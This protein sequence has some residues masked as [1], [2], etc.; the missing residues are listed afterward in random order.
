MI[1]NLH[2]PNNV[3]NLDLS[4]QFTDVKDMTINSVSIEHMPD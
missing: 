2:L 4:T 1:Q 3:F